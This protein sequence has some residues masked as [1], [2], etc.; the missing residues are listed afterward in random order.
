MIH[1]DDNERV[2]VIDRVLEEEEKEC[3]TKDRVKI[4]GLAFQVVMTYILFGYLIGSGIK[5]VD[6][7]FYKLIIG[8][9]FLSVW[10]LAIFLLDMTTE[11]ITK[12]ICYRSNC[13]VKCCFRFLFVLAEIAGGCV[14]GHYL[15]I[16]QPK[17]VANDNNTNSIIYW[18]AGV[19]AMVLSVAVLFMILVIF[20]CVTE[21]EEAKSGIPTP[22]S[23]EVSQSC[24]SVDNS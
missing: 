20:G 14:L 7:E 1:H 12:V 24:H 23:S 11:R 8:C 6:N 19:A 9:A 21:E 17:L 22:P 3:C 15:S 18:T 5:F 2:V 4:F 16:T 13:L 10:I